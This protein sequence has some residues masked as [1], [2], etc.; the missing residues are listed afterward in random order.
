MTE[1][2]GSSRPAIAVS[3]DGTRLAYRLLPGGKKDRCVLVHSLAMDGS[4][5]SGVADLLRQDADILLYDCRGHGQSDKPPGPYS[6]ELFA[7]DLADLLD[8]VGWRSAVV[9]GAS[10]GGCVTLAFAGAYPEKLDGI[11]LIDTTAWYGPSAPA[12]WEE[13]AQKALAE[14]LEAL[15]EFQKSRWLGETFQATH[16]EIVAAAVA[17]FL[18]ND[19]AAYAETCRMLGRCDMRDALVGIDVPTRIVV[20]AED[21]AT[22]VAMAQSLRQAIAGARLEVIAGARH[23][24]PLECPEVIASALR[25]L[26]VAPQ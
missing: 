12:H 6:V 9:A 20:G 16:P 8:A 3:R 4:F 15:V 10:M 21:Y 24:T 13:R 2:T 17:V 19:V 18:A 25:D 23:L 5:W 26:L 7:D 14:G 1:A 22:P 11:G